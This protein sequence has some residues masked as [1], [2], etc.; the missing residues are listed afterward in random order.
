LFLNFAKAHINT[1]ADLEFKKTPQ[2]TKNAFPKGFLDL[3]L[4]RKLS[5]A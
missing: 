1:V 4:N 5:E 2:S 3:F